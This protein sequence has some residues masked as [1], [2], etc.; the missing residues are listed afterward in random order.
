MDAKLESKTVFI[1][2]CVFRN[3]DFRFDNDVFS[4]FKK[5]CREGAFEFVT[6]SITKREI[7]RRVQVMAQA[8]YSALQEFRAKTHLLP[9][10]HKAFGKA[11]KE[12]T[13]ETLQSDVQ[14]AVN[15]YF[16]ET[17]ATVLPL[18]DKAVVQVF[19]K[20]F[21]AE[22]PFSEGRKKEEFPDAFVVE[23]LNALRKKVY[24]ISSDGDFKGASDNIIC[25]E[26]LGEL[27]AIYKSHS[28]QIAEYIQSLA[29]RHAPELA[30][31]AQAELNRIPVKAKHPNTQLKHC[32]VEVLSVTNPWVVS[33]KKNSARINFDVIY[34]IGGTAMFESELDSF[35]GSMQDF[36]EQH[37]MTAH[38][39]AIFDLNDD[40]VFMAPNFCLHAGTEL[41]VTL[42]QMF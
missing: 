2:T 5:L 24:V 9:R 15:R 19:G 10:M 29:L 35:S 4:E 33:F 42:D 1:D 21:R 22:K 30:E 28:S 18:P 38:V 23:A 14:K 39:D 31:W 12:I 17:R 27:L 36:I 13:I 6:T 7:R 26:N 34:E 37:A 40:K 20:Y 32:S 41:A 25:L 3:L 11:Y 8:A 16:R